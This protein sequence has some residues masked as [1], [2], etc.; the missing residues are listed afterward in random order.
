MGES[1]SVSLVFSGKTPVLSVKG[2]LGE[3]AGKEVVQKVDPLLLQ[4]HKRI[5]FDFSETK[6][7]NSPGVA[8]LLDLVFKVRDDF[9]GQVF[10]TGVDSVKRKILSMVSVATENNVAPSLS[11]AIKLAEE[12]S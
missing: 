5:V 6:V 8:S 10:L 1:Y 11:E 4:G 7:I 2:Y 3:G 9:G 12:Y